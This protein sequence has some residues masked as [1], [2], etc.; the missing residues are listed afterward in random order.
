VTGEL[1]L[2]DPRPVVNY[3]INEKTHVITPKSGM[4]ICHPSYVWHESNP[5]LG[6]GIRV[7]I[8]VNYRVLTELIQ[9][10]Q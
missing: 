4:A 3:P 2:Q 9:P 10:G 8:V 1:I 7:A 5:F 6:N